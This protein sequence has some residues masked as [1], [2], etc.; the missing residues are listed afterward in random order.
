MELDVPY[1][2]LK[3]FKTGPQE[4][5]Y[6][7][8]ELEGFSR[9]KGHI[10]FFLAFEIWGLVTFHQQC[11]ENLQ[12]VNESLEVMEENKRNMTRTNDNITAL[13]SDYATVSTKLHILKNLT[14]I[15]EE[16][17]FKGYLRYKPITSQNVSSEHRL[18]IFLFCENVMFRS[19]DI[20][21]FVF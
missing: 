11:H 16:A 6:Q 2:T 8:T 14:Y 18:R 4:S 12:Y 17:A 21:F 15:M 19:Q 10:T 3:V 13:M 9:F 20:Q 5:C 7:L 1:H